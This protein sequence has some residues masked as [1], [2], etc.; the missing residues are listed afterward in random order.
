MNKYEKEIREL[1][2]KMENFVPDTPAQEPDREPKRK[3]TNISVMQSAQ[4][5]PLR[6]KARTSSRFRQWLR[7]HNITG[8][9]AYLI[10]GF[11][12]MIAG[13]ITL[14][15]FS[16][17]RIVSEVLV[18]AGFVL[19][20]APIFVRFFGGDVDSSGPAMWR[21]E[22]INNDSMF[23]WKRLKGLFG[24]RRGGGGNDPWNRRNR[25]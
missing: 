17:V 9:L 18:L 16:N 4:P 20:V 21:G 22:A 24:G 23:T 6:P 12:F 25:W 13:M 19:Y 3:P 5:R 15:Y 11:A 10:A 8:S 7:E 2:E 1:L 14:Q